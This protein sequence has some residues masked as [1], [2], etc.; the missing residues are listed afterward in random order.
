MRRMKFIVLAFVPLVVWAVSVMN[1]EAHTT[2]A[3]PQRLSETG[4]YD[5]SGAINP[6]NLFFS[7]QYPLWTDGAEKT[8][9]VRL[10]EGARID[11]SDIDAWRFPVGTRFWKQFSWNGRKVETRMI[12]KSGEG[13]WIFA[14]YVWTEDQSD[15]LL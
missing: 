3:A 15:A 7:P 13:E 8:R 10:P 4:L 9:W 5:A 1:G 12:W 11:V 6:R 2:S 14:T